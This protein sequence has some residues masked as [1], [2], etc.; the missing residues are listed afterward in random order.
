MSLTP[1][2]PSPPPR[3][4]SLKSG[5]GRSHSLRLPSKPVDIPVPP[6]LAQSPY[7]TSPHSI[8]RRALS[9]PPVPSQEDEDW[10][11]DTVPL[12]WKD[13][14]VQAT[15]GAAKSLFSGMVVVVRRQEEQ[16]S[17]LRGRSAERVKEE[18]KMS[19]S[20]SSPPLV[21]TRLPKAAIPA[22][23]SNWIQRTTVVAPPRSITAN[24]LRH[25]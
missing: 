13:R 23:T 17:A 15:L 18:R 8:F 1:S 14:D 16:D 24:S 6:S 9:N 5:L 20:M 22:R 7:L 4:A 10:L 2:H 25:N 11:R 12:S 3:P 19:D 21:R